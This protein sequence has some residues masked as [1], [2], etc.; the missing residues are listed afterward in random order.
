MLKRIVSGLIPTILNRRLITWSILLLLILTLPLAACAGS[1]SAL[2]N[3]TPAP[4]AFQLGELVISPSAVYPGDKIFIH[5][6][7]TN[8]GG[9]EDSY[10]VELQ[11][12]GVSEAVREVTMPAGETWVLSFSGPTE[13]PGTYRVNLNELT[14]YFVVSESAE[15]LALSNFN[16]PPRILAPVV[17]KAALRAAVLHET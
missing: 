10:S 16:S 3:P 4:E 12:N 1:P 15:P 13:T 6:N 14:G 5:A 17:A 2:P 9:F 7:L 8:T 11:I